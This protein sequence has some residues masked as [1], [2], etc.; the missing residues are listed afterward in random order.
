MR[1]VGE[2]ERERCS[3]WYLVS[4]SVSLCLL[5]CQLHALWFGLT[6]TDCEHR[7]TIDIFDVSPHVTTVPPALI[8]H[9]R[10]DDIQLHRGRLHPGQ[11]IHHN[12]HAPVDEH[13]RLRVHVCGWCV[14]VK[15]KGEG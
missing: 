7:R 15:V 5:V 1:E 9:A 6:G 11:A 4:V 10:P 13:G 12:P 8:L 14:K 2:I 3:G